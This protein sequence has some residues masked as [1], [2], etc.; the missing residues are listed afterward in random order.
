MANK[1]DPTDQADQADSEAFFR[2]TMP[3]AKYLPAPIPS[4]DPE[5]LAA[6]HRYAVLDTEKERSFD[7]L[8]SLAAKLLQVPIALVS[9]VDAE[10]QWFKSCL[11]LESNQTSRDVA[12]C[13]YVVYQN[14]PLVVNDTHQSPQ[15]RF[16]PL[17]TV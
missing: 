13:S 15:F 10:R 6:L 5:R 9:L 2:P 14:E 16:N 7:R 12:F 17:V 4:N 1:L 11:G 3:L 8:T